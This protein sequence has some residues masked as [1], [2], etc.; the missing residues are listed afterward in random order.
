MKLMQ[1]AMYQ[2][3][4]LYGN[5]AN[6]AFDLTKKVMRQLSGQW[7]PFWDDENGIGWW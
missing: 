4:L 7:V 6:A 1:A 5:R 3:H 2:T